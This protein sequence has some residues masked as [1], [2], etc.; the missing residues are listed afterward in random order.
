MIPYILDDV[1][2]CVEN[3]RASQKGRAAVFMLVPTITCALP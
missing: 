2:A 3:S 1:V